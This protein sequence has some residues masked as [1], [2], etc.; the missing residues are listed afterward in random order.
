[1]EVEECVN[2][3]QMLKTENAAYIEKIDEGEYQILD[4]DGELICE[5]RDN[6]PDFDEKL[7]I[8]RAICR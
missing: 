2:F 8:A 4:R 5:L 6:D 3:E 1:M 7:S